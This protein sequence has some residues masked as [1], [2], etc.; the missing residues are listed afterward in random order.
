MRVSVIPIVVG[1]LRTL[2]RVLE[3]RL[4]ELE[5]RGRIE[6]IQSTTLLRLARILRSVL[7][8]RGGAS[9]HQLLNMF[10][11]FAKGKESI[12][13]KHLKLP[14]REKET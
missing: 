9:E 5:I 14:V 3:K 1:T 11:K 10:E 13:I 7:K 8:I 6:S 2:L 12:K 4:A